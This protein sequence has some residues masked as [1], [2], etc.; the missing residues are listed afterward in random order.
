[1]LVTWENAEFDMLIMDVAEAR[2]GVALSHGLPCFFRDG[3]MVVTLRGQ[4]L[5]C[6]DSECI[7]MAEAALRGLGLR[8]GG[9]GCAGL[10]VA[11]IQGLG[12]RC[13][14]GACA[15][16]T[17]ALLGRRWLHCKGLCC[18]AMAVIALR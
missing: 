14:G 7:G 4:W 6:D 1:M 8:F 17:E 5:R 12:W 16:M 13:G 9:S 11:G 10:A 18:A 2:G 3:N 15:G